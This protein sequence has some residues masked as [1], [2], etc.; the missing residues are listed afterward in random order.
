MKCEPQLLKLLYQKIW[1]GY[2]NDW[3]C[4]NAIIVTEIKLRHMQKE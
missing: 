1:E 3:N 2:E 4:K